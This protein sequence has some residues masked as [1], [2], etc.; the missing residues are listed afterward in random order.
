[1]C[2]CVCIRVWNRKSNHI[3][4]IH[5]VPGFRFDY[6]PLILFC[7]V[8]RYEEQK[9][10]RQN[11]VILPLESIITAQIESG[12][13]YSC[14]DVYCTTAVYFNALDNKYPSVIFSLTVLETC[15]MLCCF[16]NC[17]I[18]PVEETCALHQLR[19]ASS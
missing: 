3:H 16:P 5:L 11:N 19:E 12:F 9:A 18:H 15:C 13:Q 10:N 14:T 4:I 6:T 2:T 17:V 8:V 1:M 7:G